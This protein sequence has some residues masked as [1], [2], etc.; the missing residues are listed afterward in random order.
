VGGE[1]EERVAGSTLRHPGR[2]KIRATLGEGEGEGEGEGG[3]DAGAAGEGGVR[4]A[5]SE[6]GM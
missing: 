2:P 4:E 5:S 6:E 1:G 3:E